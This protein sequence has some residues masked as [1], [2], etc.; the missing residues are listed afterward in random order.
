MRVI[1]NVLNQEA[2]GAHLRAHVKKLRRDTLKK[3]RIVQQI[4]EPAF[5][6][7]ILFLGFLFNMG[8][9]CFQDQKGHDPDDHTQDNIGMDY[10]QCFT[11]QVGVESTLRLEG[12]DLLRA[13]LDS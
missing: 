10:S 11:F 6:T 4:A 2:P 7:G 3:V 5:V 8:E 9:F 1:L 13:Q 12:I